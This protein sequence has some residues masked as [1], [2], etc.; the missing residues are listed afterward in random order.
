[1]L[2]M[3]LLCIPVFV[4]AQTEVWPGIRTEEADRIPM[5]IEAFEADGSSTGAAAQAIEQVVFADL[6]FTGYFQISG[7]TAELA[8]A[9]HAYNVYATTDQNTVT[10]QTVNVIVDS[11][12]V[13]IVIGDGRININ[14]N[15]TINV[16]AT[17][18]YDATAFDGTFTLNYT[19]WVHATAIRRRYTVLSVTGDTHGITAISVNDIEAVIWDSLTVE[20]TVLDKF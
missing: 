11:L 17:Y 15:A 14:D 13:D 6:D 9:Q 3:M 16:S 20:I 18:D 7:V 10:N 5:W 12:T 4:P 8:V 2:L 19:T 1:M